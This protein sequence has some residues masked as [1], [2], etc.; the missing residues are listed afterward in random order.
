MT[1]PIISLRN[2]VRTY[3]DRH[4]SGWRKAYFNAVDGVDLDV[5]EQEVLA[6]VGESGSGKSTLAKM[7]LQLEMPTS[8]QVL[9][10]GA[11][12][13]MASRTEKRKY[14]RDVQAVFQDP[15]SSLN[16]RMRVHQSLSYVARRH[17][18]DPEGGLDA[19]LIA[20]LESVGLDPAAE[21]L[22]RYPHQLSGG[23]QQRVAIARAMMLAPSLII[24]DEPLSALD[25]S[26]QAQILDLMRDLSRT[27]NVGFVLISHDL[28]AVQSIA[29]RIAV[30]YSGSVVETGQ[31]ILAH[32]T[33]PYT[34]LLLDAR[35]SFDPRQRREIPE[36]PLP[37]DALTPLA[38]GVASSA[39]AAL[40]RSKDVPGTSPS[41]PPRV[42]AML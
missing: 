19:F 1:E 24:A 31:N 23:Q 39:T 18:L 7:M 27:R 30:M 21:I 16:P 32:P 34:H 4:K 35:L 6:I 36:K 15:A 22:L 25:V 26:I 28:N 20:Q 33:H 2:T 11:D 17:K 40:S 29:T 10:R 14:R 9:Y 37:M 12:L 3:V 42:T 13:A 5:R 38:P 8:G 41:W